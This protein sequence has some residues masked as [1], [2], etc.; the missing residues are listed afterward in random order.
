MSEDDDRATDVLEQGDV[1]FFY[2]PKVNEDDPSGL[3]DVQNFGMV[4][5]P[6][7]GSKVRLLIVGRKRLPDAKKHERH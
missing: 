3:G 5:R 1:F 6:N 4:L 2:R 7:G